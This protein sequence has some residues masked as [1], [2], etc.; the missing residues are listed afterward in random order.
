MSTCLKI[1]DSSAPWWP[2]LEALVVPPSGHYEA[3]RWPFKT[4]AINQLSLDMLAAD[5]GQ[6]VTVD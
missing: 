1:I 6:Q 5:R 3:T 4:V 2:S